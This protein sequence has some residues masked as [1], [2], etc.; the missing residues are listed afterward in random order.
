MR[1]R[2]V[3]LAERVGLDRERA[4]EVAIASTELATNLVDAGFVYSSGMPAVVVAGGLIMAI[5]LIDDR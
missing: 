1:R 3:E 4:G 2:A 5:G